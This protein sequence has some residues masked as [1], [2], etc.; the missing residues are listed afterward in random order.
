MYQNLGIHWAS[1][2]PAFL[3]LVCVPFPFLFYKFGK[4]IRLRCK[5][6]AQAAE[7]L[8]QIKGDGGNTNGMDE[9]EGQEVPFK[10]ERMKKDEAGGE[11]NTDMAAEPAVEK[12]L[13]GGKMREKATR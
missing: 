13:E 7:V 9:E 12:D 1:S 8:A 5:F 6:A 11:V 4:P 3:A 10:D 2:V